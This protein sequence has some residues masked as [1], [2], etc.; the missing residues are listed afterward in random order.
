MTL[1]DNY[2]EVQG[3]TQILNKTAIAYFSSVSLF[4]LQK[5]QICSQRFTDLTYNVTTA[6][7]SDPTISV[8]HSQVPFAGVPK[9][10]DSQSSQPPGY[11]IYI[12]AI[13]AIIIV[14]TGSVFILKRRRAKHPT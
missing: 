5:E 9:D 6:V 2:T 14:V 10:A 13:V 4:S 3:D 1:S 11:I 8:M 12:I 7:M